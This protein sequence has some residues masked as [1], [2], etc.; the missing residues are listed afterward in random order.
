MEGEAAV[1]EVVPVG[2]RPALNMPSC[3][4]QG[5]RPFREG[6]DSRRGRREKEQRA[7]E[8]ERDGDGE[9]KEGEREGEIC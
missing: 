9:E 7:K 5:L 1:W 8:G 3:T 4:Q 2:V 6:L